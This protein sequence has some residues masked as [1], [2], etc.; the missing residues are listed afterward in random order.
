M[1]QSVSQ[2]TFRNLPFRQHAIHR[3]ELR[4]KPHEKSLQPSN[5]LVRGNIPVQT[6]RP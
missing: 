3:R 5:I 2:R 1:K 4:P 6:D